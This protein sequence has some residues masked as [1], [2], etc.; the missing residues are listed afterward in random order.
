ML[1]NKYVDRLLREWKQHGK[2]VLAVDY[3]STIAPW[4][5]IDNQED[6]DR[7]VDLIKV[8]QRVGCYVVIH[9]ACN[10]ARHDEISQTCNAM[11]IKP[12][13]ININPIELPYGKNSPEDFSKIF[14][15]HQLCD[16]SGLVEAMDILES[17]V[18]KYSG[19]IKSQTHL[20]DVA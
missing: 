8:C 5:S 1:E 18:Y 20:D 7:A 16:R 15:N 14:Y 9:T 17:A 3:D 11:G 10:P 6:I 19:Y 13:A 12:D 4:D 2:I